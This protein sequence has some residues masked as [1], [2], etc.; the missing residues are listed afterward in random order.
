MDKCFFFLG[1]SKYY[2][3]SDTDLSTA[4]KLTEDFW[5]TSKT[6][7][8]WKSITGLC[9]DAVYG[10]KIDIINDVKIME[11]YLNQYLSDE[12]L[13]H[14]W[15]PFGLPI[16]LPNSAQFQVPSDFILNIKTSEF[17][18]TTFVGHLGAYTNNVL[19]NCNIVTF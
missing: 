18:N 9:L 5:T 11:T 7:V 14:K 1:W 13:S 6:Q 17:S 19:D 16:N 15:K 3:F 8:Q 2:D 10:G 4:I 12:I